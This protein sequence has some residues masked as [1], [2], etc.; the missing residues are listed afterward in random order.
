MAAIL[1]MSDG[2]VE[3]IC[4]TLEFTVVPANYNC[5]G[6]LVI[7][8]SKEGIARA[9]DRCTAEGA[10]KAIEL[11]VGGAFHS[12]FMEPA[13]EA[14]AAAIE[15]MPFQKPVCPVY[16]NVNARAQTDPAEIR[17]NLIDQLTAPVRWT[18][19]MQNMISDGAKKFIEVGG[20]GKTLVTFVKRI[21]RSIPTE[22]I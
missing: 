5:P 3:D 2:Q 20:N 6:Q 11:K 9:I 8:G 14:L 13:R 1:G 21:D 17:R 12:P 19:T 16:Q 22:A 15:R 18:Q 4:R 10:L 7:S